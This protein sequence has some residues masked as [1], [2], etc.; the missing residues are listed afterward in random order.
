MSLKQNY[1]RYKNN[2]HNGRRAGVQIM[3]LQGHYHF[4]SKIF[5]EKQ[6][7]SLLLQLEVFHTIVS[8][9]CD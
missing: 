4:M 5:V 7:F 3:G 8:W 2:Y 1:Q 6:L 9:R